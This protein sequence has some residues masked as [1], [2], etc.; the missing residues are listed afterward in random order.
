MNELI[1]IIK[2]E[3][4]LCAFSLVM[5]IAAC[6]TIVALIMAIGEAC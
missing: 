5:T 6:L 1:E 3:L 2:D 4:P